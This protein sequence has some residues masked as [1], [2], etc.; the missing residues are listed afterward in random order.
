MVDPSRARVVGPLA[1]YAHGFCVELAGRGWA[2]SSAPDQMKL[3]ACLSR[4]MEAE[5]AA[6]WELTAERVEQFVQWRRATG[7]G[8][9]SAST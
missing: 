7:A 5:H 3:M 6:V 9:W 8:S 1:P 4:W 2:P